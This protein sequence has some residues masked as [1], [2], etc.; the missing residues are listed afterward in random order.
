MRRQAKLRYRLTAVV[1]LLLAAT[2]AAVTAITHGQS[3]SVIRRQ[4]FALNSK[5]VNA[6]AE[7][8][9]T[10]YSQLNSLFQSIY[11]NEDFKE[12]L[13]H[14][15]LGSTYADAALM[16]SAFLSVLSSRKDLYSIIYVDEKGRLFY[17]TRDEAG[18]YDSYLSCSLPEEY[19]ALLENS[20]DWERGL[21]LVPTSG[22]M[23]PRYSRSDDVRVYAAAR[24][25]VNTEQQFAPAGVMFITIDLSE[26]GGI[27]DMVRAYDS[28]VTYIAA[29]EGQVIFD[30]SG[31]LT[32]AMLP[33]ELSSCLNYGP[34]NEVQQEFGKY[35][36]VSSYAEGPEW[37]LLSLIPESVYTADVLSVSTAILIT[38]AVALIIAAI[39]A[40][41]AYRAISRPV[42]ALAEAMD[43]SGIGDLS[44]RVPVQGTDE[45]A[46]LGASFNRLM[47][48]LQS[49]IQKE[50]IMNLRQKDAVIRAL[51]A[52]LDP[53]FLYN[54]LQSIG[55]I[56]L[57]ND[58]PEIST[59]TI[60]LGNMLR[61]SIKGDGTLATLREELEHV[62]DY[63]S[64]QKI[65]FQD[66]LD[67]IIDVP[68]CVMDGLLPRVSLQ[69][70][71]ENA[72]IHGFEPHSDRG[73]ICVRS[74]L[75]GGTLVIE[76]SDD[77]QGMSSAKL[78]AINRQLA[79]EAGLESGPE[80][81]IGINN[82]SAR[83]K[84]LYEQAG[85]LKIESEEGIGTVLQIRVPF[86]RR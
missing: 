85:E 62:R 75:E 42:E 37:Y 74:W 44:R 81:G 86:V 16:K 72:I 20:D 11:L 19:V 49:S 65:R 53:H 24:R 45:I 69:P 61:Y 64:I 57:V 67:Y 82:L 27:A 33:E 56:A 36:M 22:H 66:R 29:C 68:E 31:E 60:S 28:A 59:I 79:G 80:T 30:S 58:I 43:S 7:R 14:R 76:V 25:I 8:L 13:R 40:A 15:S 78:D 50:Y 63:L 47:D 70:M 48:D 73:I 1:L 35:I 9:E 32:G 18:H 23:P 46:R 26:L 84:L 71:V 5:L 77:G 3:L 6:G 17:T 55:S 41:A 51:Q 34:I 2:L 83:L 10:E 54:V 38:A 52:Q 12:L 39:I 21:R 4:A